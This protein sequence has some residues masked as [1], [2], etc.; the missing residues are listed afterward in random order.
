MDDARNKKSNWIHGSTHMQGLS[1]PIPGFTAA[2]PEGEAAELRYLPPAT[3]V[4]WW[5]AGVPSSFLQFPIS[6]I[7]FASVVASSLEGIAG[8]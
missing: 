5:I 1:L 3:E 6:I 4:S 8:N 2:G 7:A